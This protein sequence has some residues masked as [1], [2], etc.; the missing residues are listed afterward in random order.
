MFLD[1]LLNDAH[2]SCRVNNIPCCLNTGFTILH[3][4][5][6]IPVEG[7]VVICTAHTM[8]VVT[9]DANYEKSGKR[10]YTTVYT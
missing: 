5:S 8:S 6:L 2:D 10:E 9:A 4:M 7:I 1:R 3:I